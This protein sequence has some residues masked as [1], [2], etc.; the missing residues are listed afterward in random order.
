MAKLLHRASLMI[1][2][3]SVIAGLISVLAVCILAIRLSSI[4][5]QNVSGLRISTLQATILTPSS[6]C[7]SYRLLWVKTF[8]LCI[9]D[10]KIDELSP[11][12]KSSLQKTK[13]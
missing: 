12:F 6:T 11:K 4:N 2:L 8:W 7:V 13:D 9:R 1:L 10:S 5:Q 3:G